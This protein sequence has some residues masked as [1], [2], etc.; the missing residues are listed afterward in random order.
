MTIYRKITRA[1]ILF[2]ILEV[3][4]MAHCLS[5]TIQRTQTK[6]KTKTDNSRILTNEDVEIS[7]HPTK[8]GYLIYKYYKTHPYIQGVGRAPIGYIRLNGIN[9]YD[10]W[11]EEYTRY[12]VL[13]VIKKDPNYVGKVEENPDNK[14]VRL[15]NR[16]TTEFYFSGSTIKIVFRPT[17]IDDWT[18]DTIKFQSWDEINKWF[19]SETKKYKLTINEERILRSTIDSLKTNQDGA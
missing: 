10:S 15:S 8:P 6:I 16:W 1:L 7:K 14:V 13:T 19:S 4:L 5:Q 3:L 11:S 17:Y 12:V 9:E 18:G 2:V